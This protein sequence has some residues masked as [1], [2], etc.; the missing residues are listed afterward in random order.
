M[1]YVR[2]YNKDKNSKYVR[3]YNMDFLKGAFYLDD[4]S[5]DLV[6]TS[7]HFKDE[8]V[9]GDY[10]E[11]Y[12]KAFE[13]MNRIAAKAVI[14][15]HS[16]TKM[17]EIIR[18]WPPKRTL[19]WGKGLIAPSWRYN[20]IFVY[21]KSDEYKVNKYIYTDIFGIAP[22]KNKDKSKI[23]KYQDPVEL[24]VAVLKMFKECKTVLDPFIGSG[25]TAIAAQQLGL[26]CIGFEK[27]TETW[28]T[29]MNRIQKEGG[30]AYER[31]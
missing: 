31:M 29:C 22:I 12:S 16:A 1:E 4:N 8:D 2:I 5:V 13:E 6:L 15:I 10:W 7:P 25:T 9:E 21:Q 17:N 11:F 18:R 27:D 26:D 3:I 30:Q 19:I 23:H 20:P 28:H 14:I 24:Y